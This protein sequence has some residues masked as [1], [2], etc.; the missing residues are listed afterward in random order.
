MGLW[1]NIKRGWKSFAII[2]DLRWEMTKVKFLHDLW[3]WDMA[4]KEAFPVYLILFA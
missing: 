4:L 1:K 3:C 2:P